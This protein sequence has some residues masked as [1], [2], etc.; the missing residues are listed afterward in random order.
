MI[1]VQ[2]DIFQDNEYAIHNIGNFDL[3]NG[4][5]KCLEAMKC[6]DNSFL[7]IGSFS[8]V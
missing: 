1:K 7:Y 4:R 5:T 3:D 6:A 2:T 8:L